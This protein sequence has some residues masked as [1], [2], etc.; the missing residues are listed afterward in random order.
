MQRA[1]GVS[2][3]L[4]FTASKRNCSDG[5]LEDA[6]DGGVGVEGKHVV[7]GEDG[8]AGGFVAGANVAV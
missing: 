6:G 8:E 5:Q 1:L 3:S 2:R 4:D 7:Q